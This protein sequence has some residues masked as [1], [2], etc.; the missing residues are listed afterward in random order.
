MRSTASSSA[1]E[2]G[3]DL[4][5][6][7]SPLHALACLAQAFLFLT[8]SHL[9]PLLFWPLLANFLLFAAA[10]LAA[11]WLFLSLLQTLLPA[12]LD[13]LAFLLLPLFSLTLFVATFSL[14]ALMANLIGAPFYGHLSA[15][16]E[17]L[18]TGRRPPA[19]DEIPLR[20]ELLAELRR[21]G[22]ALKGT[23]PLLL[24]SLLPGVNLVASP[25]L[26][27]WQAWFLGLEYASYPLQNRGLLF[28]EALALLRRAPLGVTTLGGA[29]MVGLT[30][31]LLN[32]LMPPVA[33]I[34]ATLYLIGAE[35]PADPQRARRS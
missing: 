5:R 26:L 35:Q 19:P 17:E 6:L 22:Y 8:N 28:P 11:S 3:Y 31:P 4:N 21:W 25:L 10:L 24:L 29:V 2:A 16:V 13:W 7:N 9:R 23:A 20:R 30:V 33:V 15:R 1:P 14:F 27:L 18:V 34:A 32:I 12:W